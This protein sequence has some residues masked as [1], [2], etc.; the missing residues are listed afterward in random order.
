MSTYHLQCLYMFVDLLSLNFHIN[1]AN[2]TRYTV[3]FIHI[4]RPIVFI[5]SL[6]KYVDLSS[7]F[8]H[9]IL[10]TSLDDD[11]IPLSTYRISMFTIN[12][13]R[14]IVFQCSL[15]TFVDLSY[16]N[17]HYIYLCWH[18][19]FKCSQYYSVDLLSFNVHYI[20]LWIYRL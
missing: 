13:C 15:Y 10:Y 4:C 16:L 9:Y 8:V 7:L 3:H 18:I 14:L 11:Y 17:V 2:D 20:P 19:P 12:L 1:N 5:C 6:Y